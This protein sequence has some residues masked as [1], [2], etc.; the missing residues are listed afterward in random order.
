MRTSLLLVIAMFVACAK[1]PAPTYHQGFFL[2]QPSQEKSAADIN[3]ESPDTVLQLEA[4]IEQELAKMGLPSL[5]YRELPL[6]IAKA[7]DASD[8]AT[9]ID[10]AKGQSSDAPPK[11][12]V[13]PSPTKQPITPEANAS[14]KTTTPT[15]AK[16]PNNKSENKDSEE[17]NRC[18]NTCKLIS[19]ICVAA[20]KICRITEKYP[21][22]AD[23]SQRCARAQNACT[24]AQNQG[25]TCP[26]SS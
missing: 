19:N 7:A 4:L 14:P 21:K 18:Q 8:K 2:A 12:V 1:A 16:N 22:D 24:R 17:E 6:V 11:E 20:D 3:G 23:A 5:Q 9:S 10:A 26:C 25:A 13:P 15:A